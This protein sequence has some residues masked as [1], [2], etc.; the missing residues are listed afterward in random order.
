MT[1]PLTSSTVL[2]SAEPSNRVVLLNRVMTFLIGIFIFIS[3]FPRITSIKEIC[4]YSAVLVM[5]IIGF[6]RRA[7][8][9]FKTPLTLPFALFAGWAFIGLFF[10][11]DKANSSH[12]YFAHLIKY[13][14][15]F[16]MLVHSFNSRKRLVSLSWIIVIS[17]TLFS[18]VGLT[19]YYVILDH[20]IKTRFG[21]HLIEGRDFFGES[22]TNLMGVLFVFA[23]VLA[24]QLFRT[25]KRPVL[26]TIPAIAILLLFTATF[27]TQ[28]RGSLAAMVVAILIL[29]VNNRKIMLALVGVIVLLV[30]LTPIKNRITAKTVF[31]NERIGLML[32]ALEIMKDHPITGTGFG[33]ETYDKLIDQEAY[34]MRLPEKYRLKEDFAVIHNMYFN[35]A[36]RLGVIG[37]GLFSVIL[38]VAVKYC[39]VLMKKGQDE[40]V[41]NWSL[42]ALSVMGMFLVK[43]F[44]SPVF[45]HFAEVV[46]YTIFSIITIIW[47]INNQLIDKQNSSQLSQ[48]L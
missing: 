9:S 35:V 34:N 43:G 19:Y 4:F 26:K 17:A 21:L 30:M 39:F 28:T 29:F 27:L 36:M 40:F 2:A 15:L 8:V 5:L 42:C 23:I 7:R 20:P 44:F 14:L 10:S 1:K 37:L 12:D 45:S 6:D 13:I 41:K 38:F 25:E 47:N 48:T 33:L 32:V 16:F 22:P 11:L 3:P 46:F 18:I 24:L 31:G